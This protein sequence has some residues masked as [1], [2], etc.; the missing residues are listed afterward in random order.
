MVVTSP[1]TVAVAVDVRAWVSAVI[2]VLP[3]VT[4]VMVALP[5]PTIVT[6]PKRV[7]RPTYT[8]RD[9][10]TRAVVVGPE[11]LQG[12]LLANPNID[13]GRTHSN[14]L[15]NGRHK[16]PAATDT[17]RH[18]NQSREN[19]RQRQFAA[20]QHRKLA[21]DSADFNRTRSLCSTANSAWLGSLPLVH[22]R[23]CRERSRIQGTERAGELARSVCLERVKLCQ[24]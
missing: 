7:G 2:V 13:G 6:T 12:C 19:K 4:P 14:R 23:A 5:V 9:C 11:H 8:A 10:A 24:L 20:T 3:V 22:T 16:E 18:C 21:S 1:T 15:Q 17:R